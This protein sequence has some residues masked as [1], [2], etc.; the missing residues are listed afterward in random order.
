MNQKAIGELAVSAISKSLSLADH[1]DP[2]INKNDTEPGVDGY[3]NVHNNKDIKKGN[4]RGKVDVQVKGKE[5]DDFGKEKIKHSVKVVDLNFFLSVGGV[6]FFVVYISPDGERE[7][8]YYATLSLVKL[9]I[10]LAECDE[11]QKEKA[12]ELKTF[13]KSNNEKSDIFLNFLANHVKQRSFNGNQMIEDIKKYADVTSVI[14]STTSSSGGNGDIIKPFLENELYIYCKRGDVDVEI[15]VKQLVRDLHVLSQ[16]DS[17]IS[18]GEMIYYTKINRMRSKSENVLHIGKSLKLIFQE[19]K[20]SLKISFTPTNTLNDRV[21]DSEFYINL[22]ER[23]GFSIN[24]EYIPIT[25]ETL[26]ETRQIIEKLKGELVFLREV[27]DVFKRLH[28][29]KDLD[30]TR[31]TEKD[32]A[33]IKMLI[34]AFSGKKLTQQITSELPSFPIIKIQEIGILLIHQADEKSKDKYMLKDFF[35]EQMVFSETREGIEKKQI[36]TQLS[37]L[38]VE[39]YEAIDNIHL[40]KILSM[41]S[42]LVSDC[43]SIMRFLNQ[44][45]LKVLIAYDNSN[46]DR[47]LEIAEEISDW[48]IEND[49][50]EDLEEIAIR[51]LNGLQVVKRKRAFVDE[52]LE[53]LY[54]LVNDT[55]LSNA[56]RLGGQLLLGNGPLSKNLFEKLNK[57]EQV[58]FKAFPIARFME[59]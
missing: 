58:K 23:G 47:L 3:V 27:R 16:E 39:D 33:N 28:I 18:I 24:S 35:D 48:I 46:K 45:L 31:L 49:K 1:L 6:I 40:G 7:K 41:C 38:R 55:S 22:C 14:F 54:N 26:L 9:Y 57:N 42:A 43:P 17:I 52:E 5:T 21:R 2:Y 13:P 12:I 11:G 59:L 15:P 53:T 51:T 25:F 29:G 34:A 20:H 30:V 8:I 56:A 37:I 19:D 36:T 32:Y 50:A 4:F 44:E 10:I